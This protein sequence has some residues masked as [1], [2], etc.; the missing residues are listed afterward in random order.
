MMRRGEC[1]KKKA[2]TVSGNKKRHLFLLE[3]GKSF[4]ALPNNVLRR[5]ELE[6]EM[7]KALEYGQ[8]KLHYQPIVSAKTEKVEIFEALV[9]WDHP[10]KGMISPSEFIP[11]AEETGLILPLGEKILYEAVEQLRRWQTEFKR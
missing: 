4:H 8:F 5:L 10:K 7:R 1:M 2:T 9:R 3:N 11:I 6:S